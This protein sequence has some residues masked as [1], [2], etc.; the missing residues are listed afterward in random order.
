MKFNTEPRVSTDDHKLGERGFME[1]LKGCA[2]RVKGWKEM[3]GN[4]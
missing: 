3:D 2:V 4:L 1:H